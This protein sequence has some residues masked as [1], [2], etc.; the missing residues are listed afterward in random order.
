MKSPARGWG[1][2]GNLK[3]DFFQVV[4]NLTPHSCIPSPCMGVGI[5]L[6][7]ALVAAFLKQQITYLLVVSQC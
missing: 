7:S 2:S 3:A 5:D 1:H 6:T 4:E